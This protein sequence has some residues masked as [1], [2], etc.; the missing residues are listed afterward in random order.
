MSVNLRDLA[1][2]V[3]EESL[4]RP[5]AW[6]ARTHHQLHHDNPAQVSLNQLYVRAEKDRMVVNTAKTKTMIFSR[7]RHTDVEPFLTDPDGSLIEYTSKTKLLGVII[8]ER[9]TTWD[10]T[11]HIESKSYKRIWILKRL[12]RLVVEVQELATV[13]IR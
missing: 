8:N 6:H 4:V 9:M 5:L 11:A 1:V 2:K 10:N 7:M 3:G 12:E 13:Y